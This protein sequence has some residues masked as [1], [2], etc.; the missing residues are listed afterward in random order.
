MKEAVSVGGAHAAPNAWKSRS[1]SKFGVLVAVWM[2]TLLLLAAVGAFSYLQLQKIEAEQL[3]EVKSTLFNLTRVNEEHALR[4]FRAAD[5]TLQFIISRYAAEGSKLDLR[6]MVN[7]GVIDAELFAQVGVIDAE[8]IFQ[9]SNGPVPKGLDLSDREHFKVH[10]NAE[11]RALF[12]SEPV[13]GR[14]SGKQSIQLTRRIN[15]PDGSFGGVAVVS[16]NVNYFTQFYEDLDFPL[17]SVSAL[18]GLDGV[19]RARQV[20][21]KKSSGENLSL[22][23]VF[24]LIA[25]GKVSGM[26]T[27]R[28]IV[29]GVERLYA[30]RKIPGFPLVVSNGVA[31]E[32]LASMYQQSRNTLFGQA[33]AL[34]LL[35]LVMATV[36][37]R[38]ILQ[39]QEQKEQLDVIFELSPDAF[40]SFDRAFRVRYANPAFEQLTGVKP[41]TITG[42]T[43]E[44]FT[45][46][47]NALCVSASP[48]SGLAA[49]RDA[50]ALNGGVKVELIQ[51]AFPSRRVLHAELTT[52]ESVSVSQ[53]LYLRDVTHEIIVEKM[54]TEFLSTA[55]HELRTP[56]ACILGFAEVLLAQKLDEA[57]R[58]EFTTVILTQS[59]QITAILDDLL[60]LARIEARKGKDF[61][62]ETLNLQTL[63]Q[64]VIAGFGLPLGR[65]APMVALP[66]TFCRVDRGKAR[67]AILNVLSN[68]YKYG[69]SS[70]EVKITL[71]APAFGKN[72]SLT[73]ICIQDQGPGIK[74]EHLERIFERFYRV[75]TA[76][77]T[78]GTGLGMSIVKEIMEIHGGEVLI[79]SILGQG[80]AVTLLFPAANA[81]GAALP[82]DEPVLGGS[83]NA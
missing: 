83:V 38:H 79:D 81:P 56:M 18:I 60:D 25:E 58:Q 2:S 59:Q 45:E 8:G 51:L 61:V 23:P 35:L 14:A 40:V 22:S 42:L 54:K 21:S 64:E 71:A 13:L 9:L 33:G 49:L 12:V 26:Y 5:Q 17:N 29:D 7:Q 28:S 75:D 53:I 47:V 43:E 50:S 57:H 76:G 62:F 44:K 37:S 10:L 67:Q 68:A 36:V 80:T 30:Y 82:A 3:A 73:G 74:K 63:V 15:N 24:R 32:A 65:L 16:I 6:A 66:I 52:S 4:T 72:G 20:N 19:V 41:T 39:M 1:L 78:P 70:G 69:S 31:T 55:A 48:F 27:D 11:T 34:C 77:R 46:A